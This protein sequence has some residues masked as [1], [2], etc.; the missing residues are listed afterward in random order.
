MTDEETESSIMVGPGLEEN[1]T[2][3]NLPVK[4]DAISRGS[5]SDASAQATF[6]DPGVQGDGRDG[7]EAYK[8]RQEEDQEHD[9]VDPLMRFEA[10][11]VRRR[12]LAMHGLRLLVVLRVRLRLVGIVA[13]DIGRRLSI[14]LVVRFLRRPS[15]WG[16]VLRLIVV[17]LV[18]HLHCLDEVLAR[19]GARPISKLALVQIEIACRRSP[20][21]RMRLASL[22]TTL[23]ARTRLQS[24]KTSKRL[25]VMLMQA[26]PLS[27]GTR[28]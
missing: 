25:G 12:L 28:T 16:R 21:M 24:N 1:I 26:G 23:C 10:L 2:K 13:V 27:T 20:T 6:L 3:Y 5:T 18:R 19:M 17:L 11:V 8:C 22:A 15:N 9:I 4:S 14:A 7:D